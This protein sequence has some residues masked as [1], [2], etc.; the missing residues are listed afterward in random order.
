MIN[1]SCS[2]KDLVVDIL[3][4]SF[5]DN[6]SVNYVIKDDA[7]RLKR[8]RSLMKYSFEVCFLF[9]K[10]YLS[11]DKKACALIVFPDKKKT[12][13]KAIKL[14]IQLIIS[15]LGISNL[16]KTLDR[17]AKIKKLQPTTPFFHLWFI[18]VDPESQ[19]KGT[20]SELLREVINEAE[21]M[22]RPVY[23]ETSTLKNVPWYKKFGFK[24]YNEL[25]LSY[26][27]FLLTNRQ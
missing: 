9:G 8:I 21:A 23:L 11:E 13:W 4:R 15:C 17:E 12:N 27:L 20:G 6:K 18:G 5:Y 2:D 19:N 10:V 3:T 16:L 7:Q 14:D 26:K 24:I 22:R 25:H 1:A